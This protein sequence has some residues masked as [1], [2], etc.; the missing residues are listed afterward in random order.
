MTNNY[1]I[2]TIVELGHARDVILLGQKLLWIAI[3][4]ITLEFGTYWFWDYDG[5]Y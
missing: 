5:N 4:G 1:E 2:A 3:D